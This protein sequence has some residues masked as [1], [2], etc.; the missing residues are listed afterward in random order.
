MSYRDELDALRQRNDDLS[1]ELTEARARIEELE[2]R[3]RGAELAT[4]ARPQ[5]PVR[6]LGALHF[7]QPKTFVPLLFLF[8]RAV[9]VA[10]AR[11]P[12]PSPSDDDRLLAWIW[13]HFVSRPV[14][15]GVRLPLYY[16]SLCVVLP[17]TLSLCLVASL[18][19]SLYAMAN[20]IS[21]SAEPPEDEHGWFQGEPSDD[22]GAMFLWLVMS[23]CLWPFLLTTTSLLT[24]MGSGD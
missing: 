4:P 11:A 15:F 12:W 14:A 18:P 5:A 22:E 6:R 20:R 16:L 9:S 19:L 21:F 17:V 3:P 10:L 8:R 13:H 23:I 24:E 1:R 2:A 7:H